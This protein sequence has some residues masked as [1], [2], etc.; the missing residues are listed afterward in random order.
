AAHPTS[1]NHRM[2][3][4]IPIGVPARLERIANALLPPSKREQVLGD[5]AERFQ[6]GTSPSTASYLRDVLQVVLPITWRAFWRL[7]HFTPALVGS[8]ISRDSI[9]H[10]I[11]QVQDELWQHDALRSLRLLG[12][13]VLAFAPVHW[14][15][16]SLANLLTVVF[17]AALAICTVGSFWPRCI[18]LPLRRL[19]NAKQKPWPPTIPADTSLVDLILRYRGTLLVRR[20][21]NPLFLWIYFPTLM[22]TTG[23]WPAVAAAIYGLHLAISGYFGL[24]YLWAV[25]KGQP[26]LSI[27]I[28]TE[29]KALDALRANLTE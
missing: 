28:D 8:S 21:S 2:S 9:R 17:Y 26:F 5:L 16:N 24:P 1:E 18:L 27:R 4:P 13:W 10:R 25:T 23:V 7:P 12:M 20:F 15:N 22:T 29:L 14:G 6:G 3:N 19:H 11:E